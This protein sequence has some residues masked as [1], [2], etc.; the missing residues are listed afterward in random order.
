MALFH[1]TLNLTWM[2]FPNCGSHF[3]MR[4]GGLVF[5]VLSMR[6]L[7]GRLWMRSSPAI[8]LVASVPLATATAKWLA[9]GPRWQMLPAYALA[10]LFLLAGLLR[11][12]APMGGL[13]EGERQHPIAAAAPASLPDD[14]RSNVH[15]RGQGRLGAAQHVDHAGRR[16][17]AA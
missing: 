8:A 14:G 13:H 15:R 16:Q 7:R 12:C 17:H 1:A 3:D 2:L 10:V 6:Q 9:E 5:L 4:L 11:N